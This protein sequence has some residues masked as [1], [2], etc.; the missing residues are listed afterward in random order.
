MITFL[1]VILLGANV[2]LVLIQLQLQLQLYSFNFNLQFHDSFHPH[3]GEPNRGGGRRHTNLKKEK[4]KRT[5]LQT[6]TA[7]AK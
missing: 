1:S 5:I 3:I 4:K 6:V 2:I 7:V